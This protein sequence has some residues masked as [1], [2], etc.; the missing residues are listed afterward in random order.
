VS[1]RFSRRQRQVYNAVLRVLR[2][3]IAGLT[4]GKK[5]K[6]WQEESEEAVAKECVDLGLL[7]PRDLRVKVDDPA[8]KPGGS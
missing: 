8:K 1:G 7:K 6:Q 2:S 5:W 4:P 3:Q